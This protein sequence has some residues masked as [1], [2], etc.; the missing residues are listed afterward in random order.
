MNRTRE[1]LLLA[2]PIFNITGDASLRV[3]IIFEINGEL[4]D[5]C[6]LSRISRVDT[7]VT[8]RE[9]RRNVS[10]LLDHVH[11]IRSTSTASSNDDRVISWSEHARQNCSDSQQ[12]TA[13]QPNQ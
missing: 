10:H 7:C 1:D 4:T 6:P 2:M 8:E 5:V 11:G 12:C 13:F 3:D 9:T